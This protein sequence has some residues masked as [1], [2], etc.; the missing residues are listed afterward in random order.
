MTD[1]TNKKSEKLDKCLDQYDD[2]GIPIPSYMADMTDKSIA[3][4][5]LW[6]RKENVDNDIYD[7][8]Q[9]DLKEK[10]GSPYPKDCS[11]DYIYYL[12]ENREKLRDR[13]KELEKERKEVLGILCG[14]FDRE[15]KSFHS[16]NEMLST[17]NQRQ[18]IELEE[19]L[20]EY[21]KTK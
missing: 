1:Q 18:I 9:K 21:K 4:G 12:F 8:L 20:E 15:S 11:E 13:V 7:K 16:V 6:I 5:R 19:E 17:I 10:V 14:N 3:G 2:F